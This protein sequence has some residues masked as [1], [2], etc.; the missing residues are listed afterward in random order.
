MTKTSRIQMDHQSVS[1]VSHDPVGHSPFVGNDYFTRHFNDTNQADV[2]PRI[3]AMDD[4]HWVTENSGTGSHWRSTLRRPVGFPA[5]KLNGEKG[6]LGLKNFKV[7]M[8]V[9]IIR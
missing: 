7:R 5:T 2:S 4:K 1:Y 6:A 9:Q 3:Q 8:H